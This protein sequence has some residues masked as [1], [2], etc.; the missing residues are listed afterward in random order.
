MMKS[1]QQIENDRTASKLIRQ[2]TTLWIVIS[3]KFLK[4]Q[5]DQNYEDAARTSFVET[6]EVV[7]WCESREMAENVAGRLRKTGRF[8][9]GSFVNGDMFLVREACYV[10]DHTLDS[11][12]QTCERL[13]LEW[14]RRLQ[15]LETVG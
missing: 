5:G 15:L 14:G 1:K 6:A 2:A 12:K 9:A 11:A 4:P 7:C 13:M 3:V 10:V 8:V